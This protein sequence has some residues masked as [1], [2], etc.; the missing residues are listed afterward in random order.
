MTKTRE[1]WAEILR[2]YL[3]TDLQDKDI[4]ITSVAVRHLN[5]YG[6]EALSSFSYQQGHQCTPSAQVGQIAHYC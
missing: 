3:P 6:V 4:E 1:E 5:R 2:T